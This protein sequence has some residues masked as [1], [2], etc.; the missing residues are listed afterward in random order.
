MNIERKSNYIPYVHIPMFIYIDASTDVYGWREMSRHCYDIARNKRV[1]CIQD[2]SHLY[3]EARNNNNN[4][5]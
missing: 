5:G 4:I 1:S 3:V 2:R